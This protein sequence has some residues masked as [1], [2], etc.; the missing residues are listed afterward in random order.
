MAHERE[1]L[2]EYARGGLPREDAERVAA[3]LALCGDCALALDEVRTAQSV[4]Q[5][6]PVPPLSP[7]RWR[8]VDAA[9][10][11]M[12]RRE[13]GQ[14]GWLSS[15]RSLWSG[16]PAGAWVGA[17]VAA[18]AAAFV[19]FGP[20][21]STP[22]RHLV[23]GPIARREVA[24]APEPS[25][26]EIQVPPHQVLISSAKRARSG[27]SALA[28]RTSVP[29]GSAVSTEK[30]G[31]LALALP[32]GSRATLLSES[33]VKLERAS[34]QTVRLHVERGTLLVAASHRAERAFTV[35]AGELEIRVVGTRFL[36]E[37]DDDGV[38]VAVHEGVVEAE[39]GGKVQ[40]IPAGQSV[41][42]HRG[43]SS[44][45]GL[46]E[47]Q[48]VELA[49]LDPPVAVRIHPASPERLEESDTPPIPEIDSGAS[50]ASVAALP[51]EAPVP[52]PSPPLL[53]ARGPDAGP[54]SAAKV[55]QAPWPP[56]TLPFH[57]DSRITP[58]NIQPD[59]QQVRHMND[60]ADQ[61][62]CQLA[63][64]RADQWLRAA[65]GGADPRLRRRVR[66]TQA[67]CYRKLGMEDEARAVEQLP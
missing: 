57:V 53:D 9:V 13:L 31:E 27:K 60:L 5:P 42:F 52:V 55:R 29:E 30:Q 3:H 61:G 11:E 54:K 32:D 66:Q 36:V 4:L 56:V 17:A 59:E 64:D 2:W 46:S 37:R 65:D 21:F 39:L 41:R 26:A 25:I 33:E 6:G 44:A 58:L 23:G 47:E 35:Q 38:G 67:R 49:R 24:P 50:V 43:T 45:R 15:L 40:R 28:A 51:A 16:I 18:A 12:A 19:L 14:H 10:L 8:E 20:S 7:T 1:S 34:A 22:N 48:R 62:E 63:L